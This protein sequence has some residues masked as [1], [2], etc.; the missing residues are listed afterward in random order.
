MKIKTILLTLFFLPLQLILL[1]LL[2]VYLNS[3]FNLPVFLNSVL[4][5]I[6]LSSIIAG[7]MLFAYCSGLFKVFGKGTPAP[8]EPPKELVVQGVYKYT[9]NPMYIA[10]MMIWYGEFL[11]FGQLLLL[12]YAI[13]MT[14]IIRL[15]LVFYEEKALLKKFGESYKDYCKKV[16]RWL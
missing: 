12:F 3:L 9:R 5:A 7:L 8:I 13:T 6:G 14:F 2:A 16:P 1:P 11:A 10:Y 15:F 4:R